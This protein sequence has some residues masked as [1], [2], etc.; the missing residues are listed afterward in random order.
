[1]SRKYYA[2]E[3]INISGRREFWSDSYPTAKLACQAAKDLKRNNPFCDVKVM[4]ELP[5]PA[6]HE[7][8]AQWML[9]REIFK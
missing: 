5:R 3:M 8:G 1:M 9:F 6:G 7:Y 2:V 4:R